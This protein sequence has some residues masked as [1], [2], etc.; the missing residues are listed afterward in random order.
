MATDLHT[1]G[2]QFLLELAFSEEQSVP[3]NYYLGLAEDVSLAEDANL[4][5]ITELSGNGYARQTIASDN[6]D[7]TSGT[8]GVNDRNMTAATQTFTASGGTWSTAK[9][10][11]LATT[12]DD[13]GKLIAS[14]TL[15]ADRTLEDGDSL[16]ATMEL[17]LA[18]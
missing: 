12:V 8:T 4:A 14:A 13:T 6:V 18:G 3:A 11:F 2:L 1:E 16:E 17:Q 15:T 7:F 9:I 5:G 10:M